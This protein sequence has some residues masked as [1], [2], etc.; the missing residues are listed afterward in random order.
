MAL[1]TKVGIYSKPHGTQGSGGG[2]G[3]GIISGSDLPGDFN[4]SNLTAANGY[5][6]NLSGNT[7]DYND[8]SFLYIFSEDGT[9]NK[10][11]G[12]DLNYE[13]GYIGSLTADDITVTN[14]ITTK[15]LR[16]D[17]KAWIE[18]LNSKY[19]T[20]EFLT[21]TKQA[22]FFELVIDKVK[23]V[24]GTLMLTQ[25]NCVIDYAK[26]VNS[27]GQ[28]LHRILVPDDPENPDG[29]KHYEENMT[30]PSVVAYD[31]FW[32]AKD[33]NTGLEISNDWVVNDQ[34]YC[35]SFNAH[36]GTNSNISSKYY[37]RLVTK[38]LEASD[39]NYSGVGCMY[40]NF[41]TGAT[42]PATATEEATVN[43]VW[44]NKPTV[45]Y[46]MPGDAETYKIDI[47]WNTKAQT[48]EDLITGTTWTPVP[49]TGGDT[50]TIGKMTTTNT[51]FGI[52]LQP[53]QTSPVAKALKLKD[54]IPARLT[55]KCKDN[56]NVS[57]PARLNIGIYYT[58]NSSE[59]FP[60]PDQPTDE[61]NITL[62][63]Y[64][65]SNINNNVVYASAN[66][67]PIE[68]VVIT[69]ADDVQWHLVNGIRLSNKSDEMDETISPLYSYP[70]QGDN[71]VQLGYRPIS[72]EDPDKSRGNA[73]IISA[74]K[75]ID[76]GTNIPKSRNEFPI[77]P[78][79][80]AQ[81]E[82]I[83]SDIAHR[84]DLAHYRRTY[85][86]AT[87]SKFIGNF[88]T[89]GGTDIISMIEQGEANSY[90]PFF[91][92]CHH[93]DGED[94][95][96]NKLYPNPNYTWAKS[97]NLPGAVSW[98]WMGTA[99]EQIILQGSETQQEAINR[100]EASLTFDKYSWAYVGD[101]GT[102]GGNWLNCYT[103]TYDGYNAPTPPNHE[104][105][106]VLV[107]YS[108]EQ[109][110]QTVDGHI[111]TVEPDE[112]LSEGEYTWMSQ[113]F[114]HGNGAYQLWET[115]VRLTG[116][117]GKKGEDGN[118]IE[119]I[120]TRNNGD[121][122]GDPKRPYAPWYDDNYGTSDYGKPVS[123]I[124][125]WW[126]WGRDSSETQ[127]TYWDDH[128]LGV[129]S[130]DPDYWN[131][132]DPSD[133]DANFLFEY[134]SQRMK[135][136]GV[137]SAYTPPVVWSNWGKKGQDGDG[138]E[139][140][141]KHVGNEID[142]DNVSG[143]ENPQN[144]P[145]VDS[146]EYYGPTGY[147]WSD[148]PVGVSDDPDETIEYCA[149]RKKKD[150]H[151]QKFKKPT[152][153]AHWADPGSM[154]PPGPQGPAGPS[155]TGWALIDNGSSALYTL[156]LDSNNEIV[157]SFRVNLYFQVCRTTGDTPQI[158]DCSSVINAGLNVYV[159]MDQTKVDQPAS[160]AK[161]WYKLQP[162][163][164]EANENR[165]VFDWIVDPEEPYYSCNPA[166]GNWTT[167]GSGSDAQKENQRNNF[168]NNNVQFLVA[169]AEDESGST[170]IEKDNLSDIKH[171]INIPMIIS[172]NA[173][174]QCIIRDKENNASWVNL[175]TNAIGPQG[176]Q[177]PEKLGRQINIL[178][179]DVTGITE[180][181]TQLN[182]NLWGE[183]GPQGPY[184]SQG[185]IGNYGN[186]I[187][188]TVNELSETREKI[189]RTGIDIESGKITIS[190]DNTDIVGNLNIKKSDTGILVY[191]QNGN[192]RVNILPKETPTPA[193]GDNNFSSW[194]Q[195][196]VKS[197]ISTATP[198]S[199]TTD[200]VS[201]GSYASGNSISLTIIPSIMGELTNG[202]WVENNISSITC[203]VSLYR[204][205][206][207]TPAYTTNE[208]ISRTTDEWGRYIYPSFDWNVSNVSAG[209]YTVAATITANNSASYVRY[210]IRAEVIYTK[211][212]DSL[213]YVGTD[214]V[215][216]GESNLHYAKIAKDG[217]EFRWIGIDDNAYGGT[218]IKMSNDGFQKSYNQ[219]VMS[220]PVSWVAADGY[221]HPTILNNNSSD[222]IRRSFYFGNQFIT[223][224]CYIAGANDTIIFVDQY[225]T[226]YNDLYIILG[227]GCNHMTSM[228][229]LAGR[230]IHVRNF[231]NKTVYLCAG[232]NHCF[233]LNRDN[234][235]FCDRID[236][237]HASFNMMSI[238][239]VVSGQN[240]CTWEIQ[241]RA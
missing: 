47:G 158:L 101:S 25:A 164:N 83:G 87:G 208:T 175:V 211:L 171:E 155:S 54:T 218:S 112:Q 7:L 81:Y 152:I 138:Y 161:K 143:Y 165:F 12:K 147:E 65:V 9:V 119:F 128:P 187:Q 11:K 55:F 180:E 16:V 207:L 206:S 135:R 174:E 58:D 66:T 217:F 124:N 117:D 43:T 89:G 137:W 75:T 10:L 50:P 149:V 150:G 51:I 223:D 53:L 182:T 37:W 95:S 172:P 204:N 142:W 107:A 77:V 27:Q 44:I 13:T 122:E 220:G 162:A 76:Q 78:P 203:A 214:G 48:Y 91:A 105:D 199:T 141:Y 113:V 70:Q 56:N 52:Q 210:Y 61:Y 98:E 3:Y 140:I 20:T 22:H 121:I 205:Y 74:Y 235:D 2:G 33:K 103:N 238:P 192:A 219:D 108:I 157:T 62:K 31:V 229:A 34:A 179:S 160:N 239:N 226:N 111:W 167:F 183:Q 126:G 224:Y 72:N 156:T 99:S 168:C 134:M 63:K 64:I 236:I 169:L 225:F 197:E 198:I 88:Y 181:V 90:Y 222:I 32:M 177:G 82:A 176:A 106:G 185:V 123:E 110:P 131:N 4:I 8:G 193:A 39:P 186:Q 125:D 234:H 178:R 159:L 40:M 163:S 127:R 67:V 148:D 30:D 68:A 57:T 241:N 109:L 102:P 195:V 216:I 23:S 202:S 79:S 21:V 212:V 5:I 69:N 49:G 115:P 173:Q 28:Y 184:G 188:L 19:I 92:Y 144:W 228:N 97:N 191:D 118:D 230:K 154:G 151:W 59:F 94:H 240:T 232:D 196:S 80:Y 96:L 190:A 100:I 71:L 221:S 15:D 146:D 139:Y 200:K 38:I 201:I 133:P 120:Y 189:K 93:K 85:M 227:D 86:D 60:A 130:P 104:V 170:P 29:P 233:I 231:S 209:S 194:N 1:D 26:P 35:Q 45:E 84:F 18:T 42:L 116:A 145:I 36:E 41:N 153:W 132:D 73:I 237:G 14:K 215:L 46:Y 166:G 136:N 114:V 24:G 129:G 6:E 213:T 17:G